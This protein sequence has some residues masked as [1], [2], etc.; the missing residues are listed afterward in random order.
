M[1][2]MSTEAVGSYSVFPQLDLLIIFLTPA[3]IVT[4]WSVSKVE[5]KE[6]LHPKLAGCVMG[7]KMCDAVPGS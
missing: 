7:L 6:T 4:Q 5:R 2:E 3:I 1:T